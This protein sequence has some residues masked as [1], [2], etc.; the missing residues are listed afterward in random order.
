MYEM[1]DIVKISG[2]WIYYGKTPVVTNVNLSVAA[3]DYIGVIGPNGGGKTS[4]I[5][6]ILGLVSY[7][8]SIEF[9]GEVEN[10]RN[11]GYLPQK[12][13]FD[14]SFPITVNEVIK[15]GLQQHG[16]R[17][18][19]SRNVSSKIS[20]LMEI[21]GINHLSNK[22]INE[23]SGGEMQRALLCRALI[24]D[25]K[26]LILDEPTT[27]VDNKFEQDLYT[28]L[29]GLNGQMAIIMVSHDLGTISSHV[30]SIVCVNKTVHRHNS[31]ELTPEMLANYDCPIQLITHGEVPHTV[32]KNH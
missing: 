9:F 18:R 29:S 27:Y 1:V 32:L 26:L 13:N 21:T 22:S 24:S 16:T 12:N 3:H 11:I 2:L 23:L 10:R 14:T 7:E 31:N 28:I 8:G 6:A 4:L 15:S 17:I 25:P 5:K 19:N 20:G 30:K